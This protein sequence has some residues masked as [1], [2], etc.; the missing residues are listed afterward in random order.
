MSR[1]SVAAILVI[2]SIAGCPQN[3]DSDGDAVPDGADNCPKIAN[4]DQLDSDQDGIGD[5]CEGVIVDPGDD[6]AGGD[7]SGSAGDGGED[8][9]DATLNLNGKWLDNGNEVCITQSGLSVQARYVQPHIC[10]HRDGTGQTS[11][12]DFDFD[13]TLSGRTLDGETSICSYGAGNPQGVGIHRATVTLSVSADGNTLSGT[14]Y[15]SL[16]QRDDPVTL[17]RVST[18]CGG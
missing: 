7:G 13:A 1:L 3:G 15:N 6:D 14:F 10:D 12:T 5:A 17:T 8:S 18:T 4:A 16:E 9:G 2:A 11:Q